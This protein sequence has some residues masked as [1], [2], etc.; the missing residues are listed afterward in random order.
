MT[1]LP[2]S[3]TGTCTVRVYCVVKNPGG[4]GHGLVFVLYRTLYRTGLGIVDPK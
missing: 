1:S 2:A 3:F 4:G